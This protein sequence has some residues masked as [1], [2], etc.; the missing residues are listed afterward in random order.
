MKME[1]PEM[2]AAGALIKINGTT[3]VDQRFHKLCDWLDTQP[4]QMSRLVLHDKLVELDLWV[5]ESDRAALREHL[6]MRKLRG[7]LPRRDGG[8]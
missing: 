4:E 7:P 8:A 6:E 3:W 1:N 2:T 5:S